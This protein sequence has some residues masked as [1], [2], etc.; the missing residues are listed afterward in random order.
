[1]IGAREAAWTMRGV[2]E[3]IDVV[4]EGPGRRIFIYPVENGK[5]ADLADVLSQA[6]GLTAGATR[7]QSP[8]LQSLHRSTPGVSNPQ[9]GGFG[10]SSS[11]SFGQPGSNQQRTTG[12][13][14]ATIPLPGQPANPIAP[15]TIQAPPGAIPT[16]GVPR[17]ATPPAAAGAKPEEQLRVV[18]DMGTNSLIIYG[19]AQE[20]L[21]IKNI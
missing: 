14:F 1:M 5:A 13:A 6:L 10:G 4:A 2:L 17:R 9:G 19:T 20:F 3:R 11:S 21:N 12:S 18:A 15:P 16:P 8:T 7:S